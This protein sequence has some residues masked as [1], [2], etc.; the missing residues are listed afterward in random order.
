MK[1]IE[2]LRTRIPYSVT[3]FAELVLWRLSKSGER[4]STRIQVQPG[5]CRTRECVLRYS[6]EAGKGDHRHFDGKGD[7]LQAHNAVIN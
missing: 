6:N 1:A 4:V 5:L 7:G 3:A 2:L